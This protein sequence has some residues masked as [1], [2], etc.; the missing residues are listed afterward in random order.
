MVSCIG[1]RP[2]GL[3]GAYLELATYLIE[4][5]EVGTGTLQ[6]GEFCQ[7]IARGSAGELVIHLGKWTIGDFDGSDSA[8]V[9][10]ITVEGLGGSGT[11]SSSTHWSTIK[12]RCTTP[13]SLSSGMAS[14]SRPS[15][16]AAEPIPAPFTDLPTNAVLRLFRL[17]DE[18]LVEQEVGSDDGEFTFG[19]TLSD[20]GLVIVRS[21]SAADEVESGFM[22]RRC[23]L[24]FESNVQ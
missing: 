13:T 8:N 5:T 14:G 4:R 20:F 12:T 10:A 7:S 1:G 22:A 24:T 9:A 3:T 18:T 16:S 17:E 19:D 15:L 11:S 2:I 6:D 21:L 23:P